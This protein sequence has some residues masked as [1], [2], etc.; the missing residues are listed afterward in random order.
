[1][2][3]ENGNVEFIGF[4]DYT[5]V[6]KEVL[7]NPNISLTAKGLYSI[8]ASMVNKEEISAENLIKHV[9]EN[10]VILEKAIKELIDNKLISEVK[11]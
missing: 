8:I 6:D 1:M 9:N 10:K 5:V 3:K 7:R 2:A 4:T 11:N